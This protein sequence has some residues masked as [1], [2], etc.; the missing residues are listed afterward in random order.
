[1]GIRCTSLKAKVLTR[2]NNTFTLVMMPLTTLQTKPLSQEKR[3]LIYETG[4]KRLDFLTQEILYRPEDGFLF[5]PFHFE[6]Q[7]WQREQKKSLFLAPRGSLKTTVLNIADNV[8][9]ILRDFLLLGKR[10][11]MIGIGSEVKGKAIAMVMA[12]RRH[13]ERP[14]FIGLFGDLKG[15]IWREDE[16]TFK[17][18]KLQEKEANVTAFGMDSS[19]VSSRHFTK[20]VIDDPVSFENSQ[21]FASR[22]KMWNRYLFDVLPTLEP[23]ADEKIERIMGTRYNP[24]DLYGRKLKQIEK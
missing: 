6:W 12:I 2:F 5:M 21:T 8:F 7:R 19:A 11:I 1:M 22:D 15:E 10:S 24:D 18:A 23:G 20:L 3:R 4:L 17:G 14:E 13:F 9:D 16:L